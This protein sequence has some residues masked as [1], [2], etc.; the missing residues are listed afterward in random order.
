M[1]DNVSVKDSTGT[2]VI[3]SADEVSGSWVQRAK[4]QFGA[5]GSAA[6]VSSA[7][8]LPVS[9]SVAGDVATTLAQGRKTVTA[10]GTDEA[11]VASS[12]PCKWVS[13]TALPSNTNVV[14]IG[15]A[16]VDASSSGNLTGLPLNANDSVTIPIS[17]VNAVR[18]AARTS[19]E[20]VCFMYGA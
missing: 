3:I 11:L 4:V 10:A 20:G 15:G 8:P 13:V 1:A 19:G 6:D 17:N 5:D 18:V 2:P 14:C 12:A 7:N 9:Q 16:N